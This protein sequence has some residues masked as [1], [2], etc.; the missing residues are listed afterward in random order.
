MTL[1]LLHTD[2]APRAD[3]ALDQ[4]VKVAVANIRQGKPATARLVLDRAQRHADNLMAGA[5]C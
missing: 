5:L 2:P 4:A 3:A 1:T